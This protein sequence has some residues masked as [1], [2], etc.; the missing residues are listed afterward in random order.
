MGQIRAGR[1]RAIGVGGEKRSPLMPAVPTIAESGVPG[2]LS[3]GWAGIMAPKGV[4][5][6]RH[7]SPD[8]PPPHRA[9]QRLGS[10]SLGGGAHDCLVASVP[11]R[12]RRF[13][14]TNE[15]RENAGRRSSLTPAPL[16]QRGRGEFRGAND[17]QAFARES[18]MR[19]NYPTLRRVCT[20][21]ISAWRKHLFRLRRIRVTSI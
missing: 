11:A 8:R 10:N 5:K 18:I 17:R 9:R 15:R 6:S 19:A 3:T 14:Y 16:P 13:A 1:V 12:R 20:R 2:F 7:R 4:P 21:T